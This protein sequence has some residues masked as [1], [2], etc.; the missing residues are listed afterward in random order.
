MTNQAGWYLDSTKLIPVREK[1][2]LIKL[3]RSMLAVGGLGLREAKGFVDKSQL[4][5]VF[6]ADSLPRQ[7]YTY[8]GR[9]HDPMTEKQ[10]IDAVAATGATL[11][12]EGVKPGSVAAAERAQ[13]LVNPVENLLVEL[14]VKE[15]QVLAR[16]YGVKGRG[17][18][19]AGELIR[20]VAPVLAYSEAIHPGHAEILI[21]EAKLVAKG[22]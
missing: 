16:M 3:I 10:W 7:Q 12:F 18:M 15:L 8:A 21:R 1:I 14:K 19:C 6:V 9:S 2:Q 22:V 4:E 5:P 11:K 17:R 13:E 20:A